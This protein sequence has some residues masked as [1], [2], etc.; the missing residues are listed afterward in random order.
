MEK[1]T[2]ETAYDLE[3]VNMPR[4]TGSILRLIVALTESPLRGLLL[5][6]L[7]QTCGITC[8]REQTIDD[9]PTLRPIHY[10]GTIT[11]ELQAM[12]Q[13]EWPRPPS[14]PA[15][16]FHFATVHDYA[17]AFRD[18]SITPQDVAHNVLNAIESSEASEPPLR[19]FI[20]V[21]RDDVLRQ[22]RESTNRIE[23][24]QALSVFDGVP[25][26]VKD[27]LD[28]VPY[29]TTVGTA[30]LGKS[31]CAEDS[32][33]VARM[34]AAGAL[35]IGKANMHEI[36]IGVTGLNPIHGTPRNPY[37]PHRYT[38]GSSSGPGA[39]VAAGLSPVAIGADGGGS[40]RIPASFCG[41]VGLKPTYGRV[42][43]YG[44]APLCWSLAHVGPLAAT[45]TD[46]ALAYAAMAGPDPQDPASLHQPVP[47]LDGWD[48]LDLSDLTLGIY[49]PWFRH[50]S[51]SVVSTCEEMLKQFEHLG[52]KLREVIIPDLEAGRVAHLITIATEMVQA[53]SKT[54]AEH[55]REHGL[56]VR[57]NLASA[58]AFAASDYVQAQQVRTRLI[59]NFNRVLE[60]VDVIV[61]P[62]TGLT[63]PV[64]PEVALSGGESDLATLTEIMR[65]VT[66]A[67]LTGLPAISFP[68]GYDDTGLPIGMQAIGRAWQE[69][70]LLRLA[71]NAEQAV[72]RKPPRVYYRILPE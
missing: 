72:D 48:C 12:P 57:L 4:M 66:P 43:E 15:T 46:A 40:I 38:G 63:A 45:A 71:L 20:A 52:A 64:I 1:A 8:L 47:T 33:V 35:L 61:T 69:H 24:G 30:F 16:G 11:T 14:A 62:T 28:M 6:S 2:Q 22:A 27:E 26:A 10:T 56:D 65:F 67:N 31:P 49:Q 51:A 23:N 13:T 9:P 41:V 70:T 44:A 50:A 59:A 29:P 60:Q 37:D 17:Q 55:H 34:R 68:A 58:R 19:A 32:T 36:G 7:F 5:P 54:Y 25:V 39:A 3:S 53:L 42:S 21:D 18:G